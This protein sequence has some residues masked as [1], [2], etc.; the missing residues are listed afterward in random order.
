MT[1]DT[2]THPAVVLEQN[3]KDTHT[4]REICAAEIYP[5]AGGWFILAD[6]AASQGGRLTDSS[7][8]RERHRRSLFL[9]HPAGHQIAGDEQVLQVHKKKKK[10]ETKKQRKVNLLR[11]NRRKALL[12]GGGLLV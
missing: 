7:R 4:Q 8:G 3:R 1:I 9:V 11:E 2:H 5:T 10:K 12:V 6:G